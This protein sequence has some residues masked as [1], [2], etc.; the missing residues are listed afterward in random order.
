MY[1]IAKAL[2]SLVHQH[3]NRKTLLREK[4]LH[5]EEMTGISSKGTKL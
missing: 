1:G 3:D 4:G 5:H 2:F